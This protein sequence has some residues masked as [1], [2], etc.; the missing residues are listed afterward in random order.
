MIIIGI[1]VSALFVAYILYS[2]W[3]MLTQGET[4]TRL[5]DVTH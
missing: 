3:Y 5:H 1:I 2:A 4:D